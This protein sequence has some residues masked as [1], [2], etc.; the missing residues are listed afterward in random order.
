METTEYSP[1]KAAPLPETIRREA[2]TAA[3]RNTNA[4][5]TTVILM[6]FQTKD[7]VY[8]IADQIWEGNKDKTES[9]ISTPC[10]SPEAAEGTVCRI[11]GQIWKAAFLIMFQILA[12]SEVSCEKFPATGSIS[13]ST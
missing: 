4:I 2:D 1:E 11:P 10:F 13:R 8:F 7:A 3:S 6:P 9:T 5:F 12:A